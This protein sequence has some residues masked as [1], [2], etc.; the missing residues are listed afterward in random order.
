MEAMKQE[1]VML[2]FE[3]RAIVVNTSENVKLI[4]RVMPDGD[5]IST[6]EAAPV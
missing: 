5:A 6:R 1:M 4:K 3:A 2:R